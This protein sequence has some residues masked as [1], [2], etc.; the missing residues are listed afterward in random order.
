MQRIFSIP[1]PFRVPDRTWLSPFLNA[2]DSESP[3][4]FELLDGFSLAAGMIEPKSSS[5]IHVM[6]FVT[7]VTFVRKGRLSVKMKGPQQA[8]PYLVHAA[9]GQA[10]LTEPGEYLQL[11]ND[12]EEP[13]EVLYVVSPAYTFEMS[14]DGRVLYDD[15]VVLDDGWDALAASDWRPSKP[16]PTLAQ[17]SEAAQRLALRKASM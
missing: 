7:Q 11:I 3:L 5:K 9:E 12:G 17:R 8:H 14:P 4:P 15:S 13:C 10:A 2:K 16:T 1:P 6:P